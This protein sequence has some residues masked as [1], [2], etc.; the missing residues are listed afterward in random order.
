MDK[1]KIAAYAVG[2]TAT[3]L[4]WWLGGFNFDARGD[5]LVFWFIS[6]NGSGIVAVI[7]MLTIKDL[8]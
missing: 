1:Q 7:T 8:S 4:T 3:T 6:A 5:D 2:F